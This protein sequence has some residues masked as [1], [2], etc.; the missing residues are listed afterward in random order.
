MFFKK[1]RNGIQEE[2]ETERMK[3]KIEKQEAMIEYVA[4]M[5]DVEL[6]EEEGKED[7]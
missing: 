4:V 6:P 2:R 5:A 7:E 1:N 3:A